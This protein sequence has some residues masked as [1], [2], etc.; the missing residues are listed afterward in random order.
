MAVIGNGDQTA[1]V[2]IDLQNDVV[3]E[4]WDRDGVISRTSALI[5]RAREENVPVIF[6]QHAD[7]GLVAGS[8]AW[9]IV[10]ELVPAEGEPVI[11]KHYPDSF[12][13]TTLADTLAEI[14]ASHLVVAGAQTD[15]CI[16]FTT[17]R[18]LAEG[19]DLTL[20]GDCHTT[21]DLDYAGV[22]VRAKDVIDH[23]NLVMHFAAYPDRVA[24]VLTHDAVSFR[25]PEGE[26]NA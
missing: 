12:E 9:Q 13:G 8:D 6:V 20:V 15:A 11:H 24:R 25:L 19:Y 4:A 5:E 23:T 17:H 21:N 14:G 3:A 16:R 7:E 1:L 26:H 10:P 22:S 18:A 2:V